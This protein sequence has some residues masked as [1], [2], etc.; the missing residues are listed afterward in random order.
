MPA[1]HQIWEIVYRLHQIEDRT[2]SGERVIL[3]SISQKAMMN[4]KRT[5]Q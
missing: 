2:K 3:F 4:K 1:P 5:Y